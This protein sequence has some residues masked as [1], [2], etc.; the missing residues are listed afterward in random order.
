[1][2]V[3]VHYTVKKRVFNLF[4][5]EA[6]YT[7]TYSD[8]KKKVE[9]FY[10][11]FNRSQ[12]LLFFVVCYKDLDLDNVYYTVGKISYNSSMDKYIFTKTNDEI[13]KNVCHELGFDDNNTYEKGFYYKTYNIDDSEFSFFNKNTD[14]NLNKI[15]LRFFSWDELISN[16]KTL[17]EDLTDIIFNQDN[18]LKIA[19]TYRP[20]NKYSERALLKKYQSALKQIG[21][22]SEDDLNI[23]LQTLHGDIGEFIMHIMLSKFLKEHADNKYIYPKL[24][25]KTSAQMAVFGNDGTIYIPETKE[26]FYLE[27]KFYKKIDEAI[28]AAISSLKKHNEVCAENIEHRI[29]L[30]R[31]IRT[32]ELDE[33]LELK[34]GISE[35]LVIFAMGDSHMKYDE[36]LSLVNSSS[37]LTELKNNYSVV[38]FVLPII[39]KSDFLEHFKEVSKKVLEK[40]NEE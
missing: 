26:I 18:V 23:G 25:F 34:E 27:A 22:I 7:F 11:Q 37:N 1:M 6:P 2:K 17:F 8:R 40:V 14:E 29:E 32:D 15:K 33:V 16:K 28:A 36:I 12:D 19:S 35:N 5:N 10:K 20:K 30:F 9:G 13:Q 38:L 4:S 21:F 24:V 39:S 3:L 31:N